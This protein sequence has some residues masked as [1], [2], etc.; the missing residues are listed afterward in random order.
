MTTRKKSESPR[1]M[2]VGSFPDMF[3]EGISELGFDFFLYKS[4]KAE[5]TK[6]ADIVVVGLDRLDQAVEYVCKSKAVPVVKK[7]TRSFVD[8]N[9]LSE[10]GNAFL[11]EGGSQWHMLQ[12]LIRAVETYKFEYDWKVVCDQVNQLVLENVPTPV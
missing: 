3:L 2:L 9:P 6:D 10:E 11:Y 7:G 5:K 12:A 8:F 4:S 1:I